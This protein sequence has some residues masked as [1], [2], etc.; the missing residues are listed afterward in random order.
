[1]TKEEIEEK[2]KKAQERTKELNSKLKDLQKKD[3]SKKLH[4]QISIARSTS[5]AK[6]SIK[7]LASISKI[8]KLPEYNL[9]LNLLNQGFLKLAEIAETQEKTK[10]TETTTAGAV[11]NPP[12]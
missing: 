10:K 7:D 2:L 12:R 5:L 4:Y 3:E 8:I 1:M 9:Q 6:M 11:N